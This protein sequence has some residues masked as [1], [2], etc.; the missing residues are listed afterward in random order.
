M[1]KWEKTFPDELWIE[2][3]RLTAWKGTVSQRPKYWGRLVMEPVY[4][5]LDA[6][7][8]QWLRDHAP[9]PRHGQNY[10]QW[11]SSQYGLKKLVEHIRM[12]IG[13]ARTCRTM[14]ELQDR[15]AEL[16]G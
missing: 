15:M 4:D 5:Y 7:V 6:D 12:L 16:N 2:F 8:A 11:V 1:R 14:T 13:V 3:A 10:H 9:A